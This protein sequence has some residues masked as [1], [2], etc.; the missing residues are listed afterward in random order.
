MMDE[1]QVIH[2]I[3][4]NYFKSE[5]LDEQQISESMIK[6]AAAIQEPGVKLVHLG[7]VLFMVIVRGEGVV[8]VH[9]LGTEEQPRELANDF[10]MLSKYLKNIGVKT[11]YTYTGD[12]RFGRLAKMTGLPVKSFDIKVED[13]PMT[14]YVMEM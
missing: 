5:G 2:D 1:N 14:A 8:E 6:L 7:N 10:V 3:A 11:A 12:K 13:K 9:T 4:Y